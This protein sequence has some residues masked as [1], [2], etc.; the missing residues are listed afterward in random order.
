MTTR[1]CSVV[2]ILTII[3]GLLNFILGV[4]ILAHYFKENHDYSKHDDA[5]SR[6]SR[7]EGWRWSVSDIIRLIVVLIVLLILISLSIGCVWS[8]F[9]SKYQE[10]LARG[11]ENC[12]DKHW[13]SFNP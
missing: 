4:P 7:D 10:L 2:Q 5:L 11:K 13:L 12:G 8:G 9:E 6:E 1:Q 3:I